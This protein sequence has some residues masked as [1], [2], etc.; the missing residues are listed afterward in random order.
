MDLSKL[1]S[2][3]ESTMPDPFDPPTP[4]SRRAIDPPTPS[5]RRAMD[6]PPI[7]PAKEPKMDDAMARL[8]SPPVTPATRVIHSVEQSP[9]TRTATDDL[10]LFLACEPAHLDQ[11]LFPPPM[12][13]TAE[14]AE[15]KLNAWKHDA[16]V[17]QHMADDAWVRYGPARPT[18]DEYLLALSCIPI[19]S[20]RY[21]ENPRRWLQQE[22]R[23]LAER[24]GGVNRIGKKT[25]VDAGPAKMAPASASTP[26]PAARASR[27]RAGP[28]PA[29]TPRPVRTVR[30][31][32][33]TPAPRRSDPAD[34]LDAAVVS[35][36]RRLVGVG[37]EDTDF[38]SLPDY[39]P[40]TS[41]L[42]PHQPKSLKADW[43]GQALDLS[44]DPH[45]S[46]LHEAELHLAATLRLSCATYLCSKRRIFAARL[47]ALR[48]G[49]EFRKT[50]SQQACKIDVNKASKLWTA[51]ER[52][53]WL[54][55]EHFQ[56]YL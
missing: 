51:Y 4:S 55:A 37:R 13:P 40:P 18:R 35:P 27:L 36:S 1:L 38:D 28:R 31:P 42:P 19:V 5:G 22:R 12:S 39:A 21:A 53:G 17:A 15:Q 2:P 54:K 10:P 8:P 20:K 29:R 41:T 16:I 48:V 49:K 9:L 26:T 34:A 50:D 7:T 56:R 45:R 6:Y 24:F 23:I 25:A 14:A 3:P 11:P 44:H 32:R 30:P 43:R 33:T 52:V 46:L 47:D